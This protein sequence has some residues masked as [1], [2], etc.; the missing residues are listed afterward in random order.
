MQ[1]R[2]IKTDKGC[3]ENSFLIVFSNKKYTMLTEFFSMEITPYYDIIVN[4][5]EEVLDDVRTD[6]YYAGNQFEMEIGKEYTIIRD[7]TEEERSVK[8]RTK[9]LLHLANQYAEWISTK[10]CDY[11]G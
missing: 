6:D 2:I 11:Y 10:D 3:G 1:Y 7:L 4:I 5:I 8:I 9:A